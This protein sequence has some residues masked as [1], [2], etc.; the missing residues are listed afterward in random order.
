MATTRSRSAAT[1]GEGLPAPTNLRDAKKTQAALRQ[2]EAGARQRHPAGKKVAPAATTKPAPAKAAKA[3]AKVEAEKVTYSATGRGGVTNRRSSTTA[4]SH[5]VD[6]KIANRRGQQFSR[7]VIVGM[8]ASIEAAQKV[9]DEINGGSAG[10][11]WTDA[12][13]V[14]ATPV[15]TAV[16]A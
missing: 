14:K 16:S 6:V 8:Y 15:S 2:A 3:A 5:A 12:V 7:G 13:V 10:S 1:T 9:A 4:L 11:D